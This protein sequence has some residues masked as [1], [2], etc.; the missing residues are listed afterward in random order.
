MLAWRES[1]AYEATTSAAGPTARWQ[2]EYLMR[3]VGNGRG[4][5]LLWIFALS[6]FSGLVY[7]S[8]WTQYLGLVLGHSAHAQSLVLVLFMG[9]MALGAWYVSRRSESMRRPLLRSYLPTAGRKTRG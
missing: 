9:G 3:H 4:P 2:G 5:M 1:G 6:G 8:I 7:Q